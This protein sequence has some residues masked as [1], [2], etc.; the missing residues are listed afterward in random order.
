VT[1]AAWQSFLPMMEVC[2]P[3]QGAASVR[4]EVTMSS[5]VPGSVQF[6]LCAVTVTQPSGRTLMMV[7]GGPGQ[8][9][10]CNIQ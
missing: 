3:L 2:A 8:P 7:R 6:I 5:V 10:Q 9:V 4:Y 1:P